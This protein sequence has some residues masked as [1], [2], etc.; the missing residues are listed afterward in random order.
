MRDRP[1]GVTNANSLEY[2]FTISIFKYSLLMSD[3]EK[4]LE[5]IISENNSSSVGNW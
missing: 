5:S 4:Y 3:L 2:F 1:K